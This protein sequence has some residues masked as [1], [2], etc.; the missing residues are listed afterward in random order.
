MNIK[1]F[2]FGIV[3]FGIA[4]TSASCAKGEKPF[5]FVPITSE[6]E[7]VAPVIDTSTFTLDNTPVNFTAINDF[8]GQVDE[9]ASDNRFIIKS[10]NLL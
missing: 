5:P 4:L 7:Y 2:V 3:L 6:E 9:E 8:H 1:H 10:Q